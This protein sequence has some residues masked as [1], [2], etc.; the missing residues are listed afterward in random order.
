MTAAFFWIAAGAVALVPLA[1]V[2][3]F[4]KNWWW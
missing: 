1:I 4:L 2:E 3:Y